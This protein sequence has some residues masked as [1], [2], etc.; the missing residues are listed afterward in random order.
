MKSKLGLLSTGLF[1]LGLICYVVFAF[2]TGDNA[3]LF[4]S[5]A[6]SFIGFALALFAVKDLFK[7]VGLIGNGVV[8]FIA[9]ILPFI[10]TT[11]FWNTP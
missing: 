3:F 6:S 11:F 7:R 1:V 10:I 5:I 8:I 4:I 9:I 2:L